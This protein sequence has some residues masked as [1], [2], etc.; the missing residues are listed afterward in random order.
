MNSPTPYQ[1]P[2][3]AVEATPPS[4]HESGH[5]SAIPKVFGI[6]H[7]V[8]GV[9]GIIVLIITLGTSVF[10]QQV[11][12]NLPK[13]DPEFD[14]ALSS[15]N[16]ISYLD[17]ALGLIFAIVL[18]VAGVLLLKYKKSG[19]SLTVFYSIAAII[20]AVL[21]PIINYSKQYAVM[22]SQLAQGETEMDEST[23]AVIVI[24]SLSVGAIVA[25]IYP[26]LCLIFL[27]KEKVKQVLH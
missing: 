16:Q 5:R 2:N 6:I 10:L 7:L 26:I 20:W 15:I 3:S 18:I 27:N 9:F 22:R 1:T 17:S 21:S 14:Q 4:D 19:R 12:E 23:L 11:A 13:D 24:G 8:F 25:L